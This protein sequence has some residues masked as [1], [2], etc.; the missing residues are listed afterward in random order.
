MFEGLRPW[1]MRDV[2]LVT[3]LILCSRVPTTADSFS[4][5]Y[6]KLSMSPFQEPGFYC[7]ITAVVLDYVLLV[8]GWVA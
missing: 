7:C 2:F 5:G 1:D 6:C 4:Q 3:L 8:V